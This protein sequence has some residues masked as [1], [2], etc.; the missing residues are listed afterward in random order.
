MPS[1]SCGL[2]ESE[3]RWPSKQQAIDH[4]EERHLETLLRASIERSDDDPTEELH[5]SESE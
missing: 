2:C 5:V 4:V 1:W 3:K